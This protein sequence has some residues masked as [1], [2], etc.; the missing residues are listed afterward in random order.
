M[1]LKAYVHASTRVLDH[2]S[3]MQVSTA[4][5]HFM[6]VVYWLAPTAHILV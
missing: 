4:I 5:M 2:T 3:R 1:L 6:Y